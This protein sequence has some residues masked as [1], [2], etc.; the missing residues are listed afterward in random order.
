[1]LKDKIKGVKFEPKKWLGVVKKFFSVF[2]KTLWEYL[3]FISILFL[4]VIGNLAEGIFNFKL[5]KGVFTKLGLSKVRPFCDK[6]IARIDRKAD[7]DVSSIYIIELAFKNMSSKKIRSLV[8][9]GGV[10]VGVGAIVFLVSLGYGLERMVI[11]QVA[12]LDELKII[13]VSMT[14]AS[15][16]LS[17][18]DELVEKIKSIEGVEEVIPMVSMVS[19]I[20]FNN[21]VSDIMSFGVDE[22]YITA[23]G[24]KMVKGE[25]VDE[26]MDLS[27]GEGDVEGVSQE[28]KKV[29][30]GEK[31]E[32][33]I[34]NFNVFENESV[35][36][37]EECGNDS[38]FLGF[39][40]RSEGEMVGEQVFGD[41]YPYETG[42]GVVWVNDGDG[43]PLSFWVRA[44]VPLWM[45]DENDNVTPLLDKS[46][47]QKWVIGCMRQDKLV[48]DS[49]SSDMLGY[50][51]LDEYLSSDD[52]NGLVLGDS[53]EASE[54]AVMVSQE[55]SGSTSVV[56]KETDDSTDLSFLTVGEGDEATASAGL[57]E[58]V[59]TDESG[60]E[61]VEFKT[62]DE[63]EKEKV[64]KYFGVPM[65]K[66]YVSKSM[67]KLLEVGESDAVGKKFS[68]GFVLTDSLIPGLLGK[69]QSED[70]EF[71][72][73]GIV[74]DAT[75]S[76]FYFA[77]SDAKRL[78]IKNYSQ[79][80]LVV[81]KKELVAGIRK[82]VEH[83]GLRT[84][85][86]LDT[87]E[88]IENLFK[89][90]RLLLGMLGTV[91]LAVAS[92]GM[93]NTM[94]VSLL[95]RTREVGVMKA[96]GM[97]PGEVKD[98]FLAE[99][100]IMGVG[101]GVAGVMFGVFLGKM[102]SFILSSVSVLKG[103]SFINISYVPLFFIIFIL[104]MSFM[105]GI[106][107]GWYPS[108]R[109]REISALNALRYE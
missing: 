93:F 86:T 64:V 79:L 28:I 31:T 2:L 88:E 3:V 66:A 4:Y 58:I 98:L 90:V 71:V 56:S 37:R 34:F 78:G 48:I 54:S 109:A 30:W 82:D 67:L 72:I 11:R 16:G 18:N 38:D 35:M 59:A 100:I 103:Q 9:V 42:N 1:M 69:G 76:Y 97:L 106:V 77:L 68:V 62:G 63:E 43:E 5:L 92:L 50:S 12:R 39:L 107:T 65:A 95:E 104:L 81:S 96:M 13:D 14:E 33:S 108:K 41:Y 101:G 61:W 17:M 75:N 99:S 8:T 102:L 70:V 25:L 24:V 44:K 83:L 27:M 74:D 7:G 36:I 23:S 29:L 51:S 15:S 10:A 47:K 57:F 53:D 105:V 6:L 91:A 87:V 26:N 20:G 40:V 89:N 52:V 19:K 45:I 84:T 55:A 21:S 22:R 73:D 94:T 32:W 60:T 46:G 85:S 49:E 80:K